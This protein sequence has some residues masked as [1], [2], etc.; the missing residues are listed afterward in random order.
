VANK[1][2]QSE[3]LRIL[4]AVSHYMGAHREALHSAEDSS[5]SR[6]EADKPQE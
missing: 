3:S 4:A 6:D 1:S 5:G 2:Q